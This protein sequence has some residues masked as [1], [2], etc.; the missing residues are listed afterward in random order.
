VR[1]SGHYV[2][3]AHKR[4]FDGVAGVA[5]S[6]RGHNP[7]SYVAEIQETGELPACRDELADRLTGLT[8]LA[9]MVPAVSGA[10]AVEQALK[11]ALASQFPRDWVLALQGGFGGKTLFALTGT[12]KATLK[13]G[14]APLYPNVVYV[15]PF[16]DDAVAQV[17]SAFHEHPIGVVQLE[18]IQGV[19]GV[20]AVPAAVLQSLMELRRKTDSLLFVDEIQTGMFRTGP[21]VRSNQVDLQPDLLTIGKG[22]SDMMF[23]FAMTLYSDAIQRRLDARDCL[24]PDVWRTRYGY[25]TGIRTVL[26]TLRRADAE[27]ISEQVRDRSELFARL[28]ADE[29]RNS[30]WVRDVRCFGLLIGIELDT[31][32]RP[33]RWLKKLVGQL[34]L[35][36][37]LN[38]RRFPL[39]AGFCQYEPHVLKLTPP[40]TVTEDEVWSVCETISSVLHRPLSR[41]AM[42]GLAQVALNRMTSRR[43]AADMPR[44]LPNA[45]S[46]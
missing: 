34:Y 19:G 35:L 21:F 14:L 27:N 2:S 5:C 44:A 43:S 18:L 17:E 3:I 38:E 13:A 31:R 24:L 20:R 37:M 46:K 30:P 42:S 40:L 33:H 4:I 28:L 12:W 22:T 45:E 26:N 23:P 29:L 32:R 9:Q 7:P 41:V 16:G 39:L 15:D 6:L 25:E 10:A 1:A 36:A 8:G 11:L